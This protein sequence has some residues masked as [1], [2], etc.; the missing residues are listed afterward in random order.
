MKIHGMLLV[1]N[2]AD[3]VEWSIAEASRHLDH[4]YVLDN[5]SEDETWELI[6]KIAR[7]N[8]KV[9][10]MGRE[11]APFSDALRARIFNAFRDRSHEGDWW[12]R[13][14]AD[15]IYATDPRATLA[16]VARH[17]HV[18]FGQFLLYELS[19]EEAAQFDESRIRERPPVISADNCPRYYLREYLHSEARFFRYRRR[20]VW[21]SGSW[22]R[23]MGINS[24]EHVLIKHFRYRSPPQIQLRLDTRQAATAAGWPNFAHDTESSW[25]E[26]LRNGKD[27]IWDA[28][29]G[30]YFTAFKAIATSKEPTV[31]LVVKH[32]LHGTGI[33][34]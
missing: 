20:L 15:E 30:Q 26:K 34:P 3:I 2:E 33:W 31:H 13:F 27:M 28:H 25:R 29:D 7:T 11:L 12:C 21:D 24:P 16:R 32:L 4:I 17:H 19:H 18:V 23:H 22:P 14:D 8:R 5:G 10:P 1:K 6:Q 9:V